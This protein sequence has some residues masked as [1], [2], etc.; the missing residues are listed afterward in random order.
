M[1]TLA[2]VLTL[3]CPLSCAHCIVD[4]S[5]SRT[6]ALDT[7][8]ALRLIQ[9]AARLGV[10]TVGFTGG[11]PFVRA[12]DLYLLHAQAKRLGMQTIIVTSAF[13][14]KS[15]S[16]A[17]KVLA[18]FASVDF[19]AISSDSYHQEFTAT[20]TVRFA[21]QA[22]K[23]LLIG[24][25]E[26]QIAFSTEDAFRATANIFADLN[27]ITLRRQ[28][29]WPVGQAAALL[30]ESSNI[31]TNVSFLNLSCP[32]VGPVVTPDLKVHGC[33]SSLL[34]LKGLDPLILG[35]LAAES[36][37]EVAARAR[38]HA[39]YNFLKRFGLG[40]IIDILK[41]KG[42]DGRLRN[43]Y[44]DVCHLCHHIHSD[45]AMRQVITECFVEEAVHV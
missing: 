20:N 9:D 35:N 31:L 27:G 42:V 25:V 2:L 1:D 4:S 45:S 30:P 18:P 5:P 32:M 41:K 33:C 24:H 22:A 10:R 38:S 23:E 26:I 11:E 15:A 29:I 19:L 14:A 12:K 6:E 39:Y 17:M 7:D 43:A 8:F 44:T 37:D 21:A 40:P 13:F 34:N 36:I 16:I 28:P 3:K